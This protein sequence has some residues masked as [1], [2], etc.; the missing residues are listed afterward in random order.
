MLNFIPMPFLIVY[1]IAVIIVVLLSCNKKVVAVSTLFALVGPFLTLACLILII[2]SYSVGSATG[3]LPSAGIYMVIGGWLI[4]LFTNAITVYLRWKVTRC[5]RS[6]A[7]GLAAV[8][9]SFMALMT[10]NIGGY[11][12]YF[13][14]QHRPFWR[15][16][17]L[18]S[19]NSTL[20]NTILFIGGVMLV[21]GV[22]DRASYVFYAG[23]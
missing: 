15:T 16:Y 3:S 19:K 17:K 23:I 13:V 7:L 20:A 6:W 21:F 5:E 9:F 8:H 11:N 2:V 4:M 18:I 22:A 14:D 12:S 10:A 1:S